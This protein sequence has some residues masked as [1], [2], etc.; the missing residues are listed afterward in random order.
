MN[1]K[2]ERSVKNCRTD[3][4]ILDAGLVMLYNYMQD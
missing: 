4:L 2:N 3:K 1:I